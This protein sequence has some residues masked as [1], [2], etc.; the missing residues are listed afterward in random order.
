MGED[1]YRH[2]NAR[3]QVLSLSFNTSLAAIL[4]CHEGIN[5]AAPSADL[6]GVQFLKGVWHLRPVTKSVVPSWD[7][8]VVLEAMC[9]PPF[10]SKDMVNWTVKI[11]PR[12]V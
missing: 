7:M 12:S 4:A 10:E 9:E 11:L 3:L 8:I 5:G 1:L 2:I 6:L